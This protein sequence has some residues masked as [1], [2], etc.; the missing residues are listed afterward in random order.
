MESKEGRKRLGERKEGGRD[1]ELSAV[2]PGRV[3][4]ASSVL[5]SCSASLLTRSRFLESRSLLSLL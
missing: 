3:S 2:Y 1:G 5:T 4:L